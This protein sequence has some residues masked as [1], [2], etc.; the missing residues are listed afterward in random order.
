MN[1]QTNTELGNSPMAQLY[2]LR[3]DPGERRNLAE[4]NPDKVRELRGRPAREIRD[5]LFEDVFAFSACD[6][7]GDDM[8]LV[9][10]KRN[11]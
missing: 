2:D 8:T 6:E 7:A 1:L 5:R 9:V 10:V 4:Q 3:V 11:P